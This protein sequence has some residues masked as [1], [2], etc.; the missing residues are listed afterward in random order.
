M[1][2]LKKVKAKINLKNDTIKIRQQKTLIE[3]PISC[4]RIRKGYENPTTHMIN[5]LFDKLLK[6]IKRKD[7]IFNNDLIKE[8]QY[9]LNE[10][11][12]EFED[13]ISS[14]EKSKLERTGIIKY[15]IKVIENPITNRPYPVKDNKR[16][17]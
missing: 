14:D 5:L 4:K 3:I 15:K 1:K 9:Q 13:I 17:K 6:K 12:K 16:E 7:I 10:L 2:Q 11:L 8:E